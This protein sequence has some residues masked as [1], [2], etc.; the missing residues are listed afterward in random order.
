VSI[1][2]DRNIFRPNIVLPQRVFEETDH[3]I[4]PLIADGK[5]QR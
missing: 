4:H 2:H 1:E 5:D 3:S